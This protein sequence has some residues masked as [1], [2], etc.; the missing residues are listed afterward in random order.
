M[1]E[2]KDDYVEHFN[3]ELEIMRKSVED[4]DSLV[5]EP[6]VE[7]IRKVC[8]SFNAENPVGY[9]SSVAA[10]ILATT[11]KAVLNFQILSPL[12][13]TDEEWRLLDKDTNLK[14]NIRDTA[15]FKESTGECVYSNSIVWITKENTDRF[16]GVIDGV[17]SVNVIKSFPFMPKTFY[18]EVDRTESNEEDENAENHGDG[19]FVYNI[20]NKEDINEVFNYYKQKKVD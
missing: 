19:F 4:G 18:I 2:F 1:S 9:T 10:N 3:R 17:S 11:M 5:I 13:G 15:V 7:A 16:I 20:K 14:Q 6:Y 8:E 12:E